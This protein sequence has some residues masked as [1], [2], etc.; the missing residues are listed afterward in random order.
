M[1]AIRITTHGGPEVL[2]YQ[3][4]PD[5]QPNAGEVVV[6]IAA[7]GVNFID[8][9][10]RSGLYP[11]DLPFTI[12]VEGA[13]TVAAVGD[14]VDTVAV[15][16]RVASVQLRGSY[17]EAAVAD[18][19][20][21]VP[22]PDDV[23]LD[24]AAAVLLQGMTAHYLVADTF[25]LGEGDLCVVHAGAGGVGL[26]LTQMAKLRGATVV[27]TVGAPEKMALSERAGSDLVINYREQDFAQVVEDRFGERAVDVVYDGVGKA[28]FIDGLRLLRP[29][30]VMA[31]FGNA[32]GP[33]DPISPLA[34]GPSVYVT[35]P[36]LFHY[37][38][39]RDELVGRTDDLY[40][41]IGEDRLDVRIGHRYPLA[42]SAD[43]H[44]ALE[45]RATTGKVLI[46]P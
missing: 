35:R 43:A 28:T 27:T 18:A 26:L 1:K 29:R 17:A 6:D 12:G 34:M 38:A 22:V 42:E 19:A 16:D 23:G 20:T 36:S 14:G 33:A 4:V 2:E 21:V 10:H 30:G 25:D 31:T 9:Y 46:E 3:D 40:R 41:W 15:G 7:A 39:T 24:V 8:T 5:P 13:G 32:S 37:I 11:V 45:G 44:R